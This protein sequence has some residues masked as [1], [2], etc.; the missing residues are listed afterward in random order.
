MLR[1]EREAVRY[2]FEQNVACHPVTGQVVKG[3]RLEAG[4]FSESACSTVDISGVCNFE[5]NGQ[6]L[7]SVASKD[8]CRVLRIPVIKLSTDVRA[9]SSEKKIICRT[10]SSWVVDCLSIAALGVSTSVQQVFK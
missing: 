4:C 3:F 8:L 6:A 9:E 5:Q 10:C 2:Y 1:S 7:T